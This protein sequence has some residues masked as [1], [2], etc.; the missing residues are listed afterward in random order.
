MNHRLPTLL[1]A[2]PVVLFTFVA[3][4]QPPSEPKEPKGAPSVVA[5]PKSEAPPSTSRW[6]MSFYGFVEFDGMYDSTQSFSD[7]PGNTPILRSD[8]SR[9]AYL[10]VGTDELKGVMYGA[11]HGR[12]QATARNTRFGFKLTPP[13]VAGIKTTGV[14]EVDL[15]GNQPSAPPSTSEG[16]FFTSPTLRLRHAYAKMETDV[17]DVLFGQ[18]YNL[19]GWQPNFFPA[20]WSFLGTPNMIFGR[21]PQIRLSKAVKTPAVG[22]EIAGALTR[23]PQRDSGYPGFEGGVRLD[24]NAL[25]GVHGRGSGQPT[26]DAA[27]IGVSAVYRKFRVIAWGNNR[28]DITQATDVA[29]AI[30]A[31]YSI[32]GLIPII[33]VHD[34]ENR[35][36]ALTITGAFVRGQGIGDL[37]TG[38]LT[39]GIQFPLPAGPGGP[40]TGFYA[41]NIDPG[42]VQYKILDPGVGT[43]AELRVIDWESAMAGFQLYLPPGGKIVLTGN[44]ARSRSD[45]IGQDIPEGG[46]P[47][48]TFKVSEYYDANLFFDITPSTRVGGSYQLIRQRYVD[49][50]YERNDR[51]EIGGLFFF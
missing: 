27:S 28:L 32:D 18:Y 2:G 24:I 48:R 34:L 19:F 16:S 31:G 7:S 38:G 50:G 39:G 12:M 44:F 30:G 33:P 36:I 13:E 10:P 3:S 46:D 29:E 40:S 41:G 42:L 37:Y 17:V 11:T 6:N 47:A 5:E 35:N 4:A 21:T 45:N 9:P 51:V 43:Q 1:A 20:T 25:K 23:P 49:G 14:I 15:F 8:G 26:L 22:F